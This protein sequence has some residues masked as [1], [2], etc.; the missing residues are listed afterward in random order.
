MFFQF[1][2]KKAFTHTDKE[3]KGKRTKQT[4]KQTNDPPT[5][6]FFLRYGKQT[7]FFM[8]KISIYNY[9]L[10]VYEITLLY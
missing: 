9:F 1:G 8:P 7:Y 6:I 4:N 10:T 3:K 2:K 5:L